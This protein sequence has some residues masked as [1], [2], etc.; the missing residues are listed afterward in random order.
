MV[1]NDLKTKYLDIDF[2][3]NYDPLKKIL[4]I[5]LKT[6]TKKGINLGHSI[7]LSS[8]M[9]QTDPETVKN[10]VSLAIRKIREKRARLN[11]LMEDF[12]NPSSRRFGEWILP[13]GF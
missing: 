6:K 7:V 8:L 10:L 4:K 1:F 11:N 3:T 13:S 12:G 2:E 5:Y 9:L